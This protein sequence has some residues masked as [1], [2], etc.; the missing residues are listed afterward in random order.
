[1]LIRTIKHRSLR[2]FVED[3]DVRE[4]NAD[5][6]GRIRNIIAAL[7]VANTMSDV[8]GPPGWRIHMLKGDM[9][10]RWSIS[11]SGNWRIT[12]EVENNEVIDLNLED[13]H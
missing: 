5:L 2:R 8:S 4:L 11:V 10:G 12:F 3:D 9:A 13:Y 6:V 7:V 1:M